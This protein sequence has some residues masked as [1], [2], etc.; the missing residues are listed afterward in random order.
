VCN[1]GFTFARGHHAIKRTPQSSAVRADDGG[2][3]RPSRRLVTL[4]DMSAADGLSPE[5]S[6]APFEPGSFKLRMG[7]SSLDLDD[8]IE[9]DERM[10]ADLAEKRR[11]LADRHEDVFAA[12][13]SADAGTR[14]VLELL[15]THLPIAHPHVFQRVGSHLVNIATEESWDLTETRLHPLELA[16]RLVQEDLCLLGRDSDQSD[17]VLT[18]ACLCFPTRWR[19]SEKIGRSLDDMHGP[20]PGYGEQLSGSVNRLFDRLRVDRP[21]TRM[22]WSVLDDPALHQPSGHGRTEPS[23]A[24][25]PENAG[26]SLWL[27][28][29]RQTVRKL[30]SSGDVLFTIRVHVRPLSDL[31]QHPAQAARLAS[32]LEGMGDDMRV[33]K[34]LAPVIEAAIEWL[35]R[36]EAKSTG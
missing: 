6:H 33:Y 21:V 28:V 13:P 34:S 9:V 17:W 11:L 5:E 29:E 27:R 7:L 30:P 19:L 15:A 1:P 24:V 25:S 20:V 35:R 22:N 31:A 18:A 23:S 3:L 2:E 26:E 8:W 32:A 16:G 36:S 14:E 10:P 12:L 4:V